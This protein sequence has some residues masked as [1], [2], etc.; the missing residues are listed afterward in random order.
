[1]NRNVRCGTTKGPQGQG[2]RGAV[3]PLVLFALVALLGVAAL[4]L[5][6]GMMEWARQR[7]QNIADAAAL[8]GGQKLATTGGASDAATQVVAAN[9]ADGAGLSG[10]AI[11]VDPGRSVT[12]QGTVDAPLSF[13]PVVGFAPRSV[14]GLPNTMSVPAAATVSQENLCSLP[15]GSAVAP[16]GMIGDDPTSTDPTVAFVS[17]LLNG[18]KTLPVGGYQSSGTQ[19]NLNL[20]LWNRATGMIQQSGSFIPLLLSSSG[21]SY[22]DSIKTT[23]DQPLAAGQTLQNATVLFDDTAGTRLYL[24]ARMSYSNGN[25]SHKYATYEAWFAAGAQAQPEG[26]LPA[27][28]LLIVPVV[29]QSIKNKLA[30]VTILAFAAFW[31]DQPFLSG[32]TNSIARG[33]FIGLG[34]PGGGGTCAGVGGKTLPHLSS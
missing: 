6:I 28:H 27:D 25:Y 2:R 34:I 19:V 3:L 29:A 30:P 32:T 13:A 15:A 23:T 5:D 22:F 20:I 26:G 14:S 33:R 9:S 8:A 11:T 21:T 7:A 1:M 16:F 18:T 4:T 31:V 24:A 10:V 12:V 17:A